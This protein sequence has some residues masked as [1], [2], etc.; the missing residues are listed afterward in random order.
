M[1]DYQNSNDQNDYLA[2]KSFEQISTET[3][4]K[5]ITMDKM[6]SYN[7]EIDLYPSVLNEITIEDEDGNPLFFK[8]FSPEEK[9][10]F[11]EDWKQNLCDELLEKLEKDDGLA[12]IYNMENEAFSETLNSPQGERCVKNFNPEKFIRLY[13]KNLQKKIKLDT[14]RAAS[15][16][17]EITSGCLKSSS[18]ETFKKYYQKGNFL[19][20]KDTSSS[21]SSSGSYT[22]HASLMNGSSWQTSWEKDGLLKATITSSPKEKSAQWIGKI[23]GVQYEPIGYW[24]GTSDGSAKKVSIYKVQHVKKV[25]KSVF[26]TETVKT[27]VTSSERNAA[28]SKAETYKGKDYSWLYIDKWREDKIYCSQLVWKSWY[29]VASDCDLSLGSAVVFVSPSDLTKSS[30]AYCLVSYTN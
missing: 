24:A 19:V 10:V 14:E 29:S 2:E 18:V 13:E 30:S 4:E 15:K 9:K 3:V 23:D 22:G 28:V 11:Y 17:G 6:F 12:E 16:K 8:D 25:K 5:L 21:S 7:E 20:C 27:D 26:K 1:P